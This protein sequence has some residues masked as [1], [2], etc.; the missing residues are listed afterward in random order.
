MIL[1]VNTLI[2]DDK[3]KFSLNYVRGNLRNNDKLDI[4]KY[5]LTSLAIAYNWS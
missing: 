2:T 1:F 3:P 4:F 5:S